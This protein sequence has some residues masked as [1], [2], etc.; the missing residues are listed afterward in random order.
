VGWNWDFGVNPPAGSTQQ[1]PSYLYPNN[2]TFNVTLIVTSDSGCTDTIIKPT[3]RFAVPVAFFGFQDVCVYDSAQF[4]DLSAINAPDSIDMWIWNFGDGSPSKVIA[5]PQ[6]PNVTHLYSNQQQYNGQ[7]YTVNLIVI[8]NNN[9]TDDTSLTIK[10]HPRPKADFSSNDTCVNTPPVYFNNLSTVTFGDN[11]ANSNWNFDNLGTSGQMNPSFNFPA[12]GTYNVSLIVQSDFGCYDTINKIVTIF[13]KPT[14]EFTADTTAFCHPYCVQFNDQSVSNSASMIAWNWNFY[15]G[16]TS[17]AQS[18]VACFENQS[19]TTTKYYD[20]RLIVQNSFGCYDTILK[21]NFITVWP[22]PVADFTFNP[23]ETN[24]YDSEIEFYNHSIGGNYFVWSFGDGD[25]SNMYDP[26]HLYK[27]SG[28]Y[29]IL[30]YVENSYGCFDTT[31][32]ELTIR[33]V[34][35][36]FI[37]NAFTPDGDG[38]NDVFFMKGYGFVKDYFEFYVFDRWGNQI[39]YTNEFKPWDGTVNGEPAPLGVYVYRII[40]MDIFEEFHDYMGSVTLIR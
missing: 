39:Y 17:L 8:S 26:V 35:N 38:I 13:E 10:V 36:V 30:L 5:S 2:G 23:V 33:P 34:V 19:P 16:Q 25:T 11:I 28:T 12:A 40:F 7:T 20:I 1:N 22:K 6:N 29:R 31:S 9:C 37:P 27:D 3:T 24:I 32:R 15:N 14:A 21:P 18:P 4:V